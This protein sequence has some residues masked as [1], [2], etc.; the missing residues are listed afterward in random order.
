MGIRFLD[1]ILVL[2]AAAAG[3]FT[4]YLI[5][6]GLSSHAGWTWPAAGASF[7]AAFLLGA[8]AARRIRGYAQDR[9]ERVNT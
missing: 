7:A 5:G 1:S 6:H 4:A 2:V 8:A 3:V 9:G